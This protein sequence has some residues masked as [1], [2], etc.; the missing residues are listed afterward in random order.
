MKLNFLQ[1]DAFEKIAYF[2][3]SEPSELTG[4]LINLFW[5]HILVIRTVFTSLSDNSGPDH[6]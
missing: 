5:S 2:L 1:F 3:Y 6:F 4:Y